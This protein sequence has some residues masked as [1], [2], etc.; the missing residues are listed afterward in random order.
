MGKQESSRADTLHVINPGSQ[1]SI[2]LEPEFRYE[3]PTDYVGNLVYKD[4]VLEKILVDGGYITA[5]DM[6]YHFFVTD[7]LGNVRVVVNSA[8]TVEQVNQYYPYG[9]SAEMGMPVQPTT[10][11]PYKWSGKEWDEQQAAYDFG[12]RM[13]SASDAR[14][15][16]MD[17]LCEK[18][19][20]IS[21]YAY[22]AGNPVN[23][24]D[25]DGMQWYSYIDENGNVKYTY[26]EGEMPD[27]KQ[28]EYNNIQLVGYAFR[29]GNTYYS[30]FGL[31]R[32][33]EDEQGRPGEGQIYDVIDRLIIK[34]ATDNID[35][36]SGVQK[37]VTT[38]V[39]GLPYG[40]IRGFSYNGRT[41]S[42]IPTL[43][44]TSS[45]AGNVFWNNPRQSAGIDCLPEVEDI[46]ENRDFQKP[47]KGYWLKA[48][49]PSK[50]P[51][52]G[53]Q[54]VQVRFLDEQSVSS[55]RNSYFKIFGK[56]S[57]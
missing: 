46:R 33:W 19:Y 3:S 36:E 7:H 23:L 21:P 32:S 54:V 11:N 1:I 45:Y 49:N 17:P 47:N 57:Y 41:F 10:D 30:L 14:W 42:T 29:E 2:G 55:F 50:G 4:G 38:T 34:F 39:E 43:Q 53:F 9:E 18:Y 13:Y 37:K 15:T 31:E 16:T 24:V 26:Y 20:S 35:L 56:S 28:I 25:P 48:D 51:K 6:N 40:E 8:G 52:H 27:E 5:A 44:G 12:A 22:C